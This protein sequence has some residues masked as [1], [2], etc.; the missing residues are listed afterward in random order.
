MYVC[1]KT[2]PLEFYVAEV[3]LHVTEQSSVSR[4]VYIHI[5]QLSQD[6]VTLIHTTLLLNAGYGIEDLLEAVF[7]VWRQGQCHVDSA[8]HP[9]Q[10]NM[11]GGPGTFP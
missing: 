10:D 4:E 3:L 5:E 7:P 8:Y 9:H 11:A 2:Y 6:Q 1:G